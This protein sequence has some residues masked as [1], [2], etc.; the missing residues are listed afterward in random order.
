MIKSFLHA[1]FFCIVVQKSHA[2]NYNVDAPLSI[3]V[4]S[5]E[6]NPAGCVAGKRQRPGNKGGPEDFQSR[7][8]R[9]KLRAP[10]LAERRMGEARFREALESI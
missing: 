6:K 7:V 8:A 4:K 2:H 5:V 9:K 10:S 1:E 3:L